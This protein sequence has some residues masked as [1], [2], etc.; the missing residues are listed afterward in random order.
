MRSELAQATRE[1]K[2]LLLVQSWDPAAIENNFTKHYE[3]TAK[4]VQ[5]FSDIL[6]A[7]EANSAVGALFYAA[8]LQEHIGNLAQRAQWPIGTPQRELLAQKKNLETRVSPLVENAKKLYLAAWEKSQA[9]ETPNPFQVALN[10]RIQE[11]R[12]KNFAPL[13][14][15]VPSPSYFS[16]IEHGNL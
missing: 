12:S 5:K 6:A 4:V 16:F 9:T 3:E 15:Y 2:T 13:E 7:D 8:L 1:A 14:V 11:L 10:V